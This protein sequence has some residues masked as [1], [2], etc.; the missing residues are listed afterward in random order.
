MDLQRGL[1]L[2]ANID[3]YQPVEMIFV[4]F[5]HKVYFHSRPH[6]PPY[7]FP[8]SC[9]LLFLIIKNSKTMKPSRF[10]A[11]TLAASLSMFLFS[12]G[13]GDGKKADEKAPDSSQTKQVEPPPPPPA[14]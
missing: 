14:K 9:R 3:L 2:V 11:A 4:S 13:S 12:C 10:L 7:H 6:S 8:F 5:W 1:P